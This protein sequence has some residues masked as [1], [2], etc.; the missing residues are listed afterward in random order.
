MNAPVAPRA[1]HGFFAAPVWLTALVGFVVLAVVGSAWRG[2][3]T[4]TFIV[5][6][7]AEKQLGT[8]DDPPLTTEG[9]ARALRLA[10]LLG[11]RSPLGQVTAVYASDARRAEQTAAP[12]ASQLG[13]ALQRYPARDVQGLVKRVLEA[14]SGGVVVI[15][16]HSNTVPQIV[17]EASRGQFQPQPQGMADDDFGTIYVVTV[18]RWA[19]AALLRL[20]Y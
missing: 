12:L 8:I 5:L 2:A 3:T 17:A 10:A 20:H 19:K 14:H 11:S 6:R 18:P 16:G 13:L 9:E 7:H 15:V 4:T 1:R